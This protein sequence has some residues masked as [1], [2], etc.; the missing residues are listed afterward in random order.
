[1][2]QNGS[3]RPQNHETKNFINCAVGLI[4]LPPFA[5]LCFALIRH[6]SIPFSRDVTFTKISIWTV[7][8]LPLIPTRYHV[9]D[10][11]CFQHPFIGTLLY[12]S[13]HWHITLKDVLNF[14]ICS[15]L[16]GVYWQH[17]QQMSWEGE[18]VSHLYHNYRCV[19]TFVRRTRIGERSMHVRVFSR[20]SVFSHCSNRPPTQPPSRVHELLTL[21]K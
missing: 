19:C 7:T 12:L 20:L 3:E 14:E 8:A 21:S 10:C 15:A 13:F 17:Q 16:R 2:R 18:P 5:L 4:L 9:M 6:L 1:M 11:Y